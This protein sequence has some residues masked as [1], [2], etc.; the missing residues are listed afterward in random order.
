[1]AVAEATRRVV[2]AVCEKKDD[3]PYNLP[4]EEDNGDGLNNGS[5]DPQYVPVKETDKEDPAPASPNPADPGK[6]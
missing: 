5:T 6:N 3:D 4:N 1:M 2:H